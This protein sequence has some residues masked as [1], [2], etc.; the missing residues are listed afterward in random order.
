MEIENNLMNNINFFNKNR[1]Q[2]LLET[3]SNF[4]LNCLILYGL[5]KKYK[6]NI[7]ALNY[8]LNDFKK[9]Y[10][11]FCTYPKNKDGS[12]KP[13]SVY[14]MSHLFKNF[15]DKDGNYSRFLFGNR[16]IVKVLDYNNYILIEEKK[17]K[18]QIIKIE[19]EYVDNLEMKRIK[20]ILNTNNIVYK[21]I[22][23]R[24]ED[25]VTFKNTIAKDTKIEEN[26][27]LIL[28]KNINTLETGIILNGISDKYDEDRDFRKYTEE[29]KKVIVD[30]IKKICNIDKNVK[31]NQKILL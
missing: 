2:L 12:N 9:N 31:G 17:I 30:A 10:D 7:Y 1:F 6:K 16:V 24:T 21:E 11:N 13:F 25:I 23:Y 8:I 4:L 5:D 14:D 22:S 15:I 28:P 18:D 29:E 19:K 26:L 3:N 27:V 20:T